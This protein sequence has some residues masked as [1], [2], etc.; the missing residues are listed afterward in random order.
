MK[1]SILII[2]L[3]ALANKVYPCGNEY[4]HTLD[5]KRIP[6]RYFFLSE[7]MLHFDTLEIQHKLTALRAK[8]NSGSA[9]FK[10]RSD[11][12]LNLMKLGQ[13]DSSIK[14]LRPL[15]REHPNEYTINA[16][17]GTAYE[18]A[19]QLDSALKYISEGYQINPKSHRGSEWVHIKILEAKLKEQQQ[20]GWMATNA[21]LDLRELLNKV[22]AKNQHRARRNVN[23]SIFYQVRTRAPFTPAPNKILSNMLQTLGDFNAESGTYE[24]ALLAYAFA[25][26]FQ[27]SSYL[28]RKIKEKIIT[29]NR[30]RDAHPDIW[31]LPDAFVRIIHIGKL[32]PDLLLMGLDGFAEQLDSMHLNEAFRQ[33]SL[34]ILKN[35]LD[36]IQTQTN[37][38]IKTKN[39]Q[40]SRAIKA[41]YIFLVLGLFIGILLT[42]SIFKRKRKKQTPPHRH[43]SHPP[44]PLP[45]SS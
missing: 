5:G 25:I 31:E 42:S 30:R 44:A 36:S 32:N 45:S 8:V 17:L 9:T 29:L 27:P 41:K 23:Q 2:L 43:K 14:I 37:K 22:K 26:K 34:N 7:R 11:I 33:D 12:A 39:G 13:A 4:G 40:L 28:G 6:T 3:L 24:N 20:S 1:S 10:T 16:N 18:L 35:Q 15:L 19:G 38:I 21:I